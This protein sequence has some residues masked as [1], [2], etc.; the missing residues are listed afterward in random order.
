MGTPKS[1]SMRYSNPAWHKYNEGLAKITDPT[2]SKGPIQAEGCG[3]FIQR[4]DPN[5]VIDETLDLVDKIRLEK[6][7]K[8]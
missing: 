2:F 7:A 1:L 5:F 4:D 8:W 6:S 3:H